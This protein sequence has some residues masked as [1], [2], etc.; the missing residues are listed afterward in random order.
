MRT[1]DLPGGSLMVEITETA[2]LEDPDGACR[3]IEQLRARAIGV[4]VDDFGTGFTSLV[5]LKQLPISEIK[6]DRGFTVGILI[7]GADRSI[8]QWTIRLAH[9]LHV[10][11]VAEGVESD[12]VFDELRSLGCDRF[13]GYHIGPPLDPEQFDDWT[14]HHP[15]MTRAAVRHLR[16]GSPD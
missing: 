7:G 11:V 9:D 13:Q 14:R 10:P 3:V 8:V 12:A 2:I 1:N 4:S 5:H 16:A 15:R 6:I